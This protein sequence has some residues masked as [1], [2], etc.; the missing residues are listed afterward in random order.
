LG[1]KC[2]L[3]LLLLLLVVAD[4][5]GARCNTLTVLQ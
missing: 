5:A 2:M 1:L 3:L 4:T